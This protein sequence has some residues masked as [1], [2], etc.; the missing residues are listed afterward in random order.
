MRVV[1]KLKGAKGKKGEHV[2]ART[3][4]GPEPTFIRCGANAHRVDPGDWIVHDGENDLGV[5]SAAEFPDK[6]ETVE[7]IPPAEAGR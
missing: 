4:D 2:T 6:Y 5:V 7:E 1:C 3:F